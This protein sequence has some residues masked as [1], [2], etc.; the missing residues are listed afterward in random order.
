MF[1]ILLSFCLFNVSFLFVFCCFLP[2][3]L[4]QPPLNQGAAPAL[5]ETQARI[6]QAALELLPS[7]VMPR[8]LP[9]RLPSALG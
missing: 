6:T 3:Q 9:K 1:G 2:M 5:T 4:N 7:K 8:L